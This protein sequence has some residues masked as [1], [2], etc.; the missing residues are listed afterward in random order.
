MEQEGYLWESAAQLEAL[1]YELV[2]WKSLSGTQGEVDFPHRLTA[3][4]QEL[5]YFKENTDNL[6]LFYAGK[7]R[8]AFTALYKLIKVRTLSC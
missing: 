6:E 1:L 2:S 8:N 7:D 5:D 3:K 4:F